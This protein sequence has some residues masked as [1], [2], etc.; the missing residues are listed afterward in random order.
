MNNNQDTNIDLT[1]ELDISCNAKKLFKKMNVFTLKDAC[2]LTLESL[3]II[4]KGNIKYQVFVDELWEYV[5][6]NNCSFLDEKDY[7]KKLQ[8]IKSDSYLINMSDIFMSKNARK[9]LANYGTM[10][11]FLKKLKRDSNALKSFLCLVV[12]YEKNTS[13]E[14]LFNAFGNDGKILSTIIKDFKND[15]KNQRPFIPIFMVFPERC[16]YYPMIRYGCWLISDLLALPKE[17]I[18]EIPR[19]GPSKTHKVITTLEAKGFSFENTKYSNNVILSLAY[20]KIETLNLDAATLN[21]L[22]EKQIFNLEQLLEKRTFADFTDAELLKMQIEIA[23]LGLKLDNKL[24]TC[25]KELLET[26]YNQLTVEQYALQEKLNVINRE[27]NMYERMLKLQ[28]DTNRK[29]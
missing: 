23:K 4:V 8:S 15:I 24:L 11:N 13:L 9:Y 10:E 20:F 14:E 29:E 1:K 12:T 17:E 16:V 18:S 22:R 19:L 7:Y 25:P 5:H 3:K 28:K 26:N 6:N 21:K 2:N 27:K